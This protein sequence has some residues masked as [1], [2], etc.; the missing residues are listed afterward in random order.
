MQ[1]FRDKSHLFDPVWHVEL[2]LLGVIVLQ[3]LLPSDLSLLPKWLL[4]I[5]ELACLAAVHFL[6][7]K[8]AI[9]KSSGRRLAVLALI[10]VVLAANV[11]SLELLLHALFTA[12][13]NDA[14]RLLLS[15]FN[16]YV[17]N[18]VVFGLFYWEM[19]AGG[20]GTRRT[21]R[22][23]ERDFLFPQQ[24]LSYEVKSW[25]PTFFDYLYV[26]VT[27]GTA[28]SPTDTMPLSR[29]AKF[30]MGV[31]AVVSLLVVVLVAARAINVL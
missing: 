12:T 29:R 25:Y 17:T 24:N 5:L 16:I 28:F 26:S 19:D 6:T 3:L 20:P 11:G 14:P 2:V 13:K 22:L 18:I 27:N 1:V 21:N 8:K 7:P 30:L 23:E 31:Q 15:A 4:P 10:A 9:F